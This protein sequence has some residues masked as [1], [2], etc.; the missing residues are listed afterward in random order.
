M[1]KDCSISGHLF[2]GD[3]VDTGAYCQPEFNPWDPSGR[4]KEPILTR[5][6]LTS[7]RALWNVCMHRQ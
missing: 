7:K 3:S 1:E 6:P 2:L 5:S 4:T